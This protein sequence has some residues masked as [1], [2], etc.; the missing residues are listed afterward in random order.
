MEFYVAVHL[1]A[2]LG[3]VGRWSFHE[4]YAIH[5][6]ARLSAPTCMQHAFK[7]RR[8]W[9]LVAHAREIDH[10]RAR[11]R[12]AAVVATLSVTAVAAVAFAS[13]R[14]GLRH[15]TTT[16]A[17]RTGLIKGAE[18][19]TTFFLSGVMGGS[20]PVRAGAS[21]RHTRIERSLDADAPLRPPTPTMHTDRTLSKWPCRRTCD[22][23]T[24]GSSMIV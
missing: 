2:G 19:A 8:V 6:N 4:E 12:M 5:L 24:A 11:A 14:A 18:A 20:V 17:P 15:A 9:P 7:Q 22:V 16:I 21:K 1:E 10:A 3:G 23:C 13:Y